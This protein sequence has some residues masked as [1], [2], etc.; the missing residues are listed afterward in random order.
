MTTLK[1]EKETGQV[2]FN[3]I[4]YLTEH[5][6]NLSFKIVISIKIINGILHTFY[7]TNV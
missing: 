6:K 7:G 5:I 1:R 4:F 3:G 2:N